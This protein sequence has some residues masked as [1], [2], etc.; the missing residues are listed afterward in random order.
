MDRVEAPQAR[1]VELRRH[2]EKRIIEAKQAQSLEHA[3]RAGEGG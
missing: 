1:T 3:S 2:V